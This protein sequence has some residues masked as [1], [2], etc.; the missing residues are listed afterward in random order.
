MNNPL[1]IN[2]KKW[3]S[4]KYKIPIE[5]LERIEY[6]GGDV[7]LKIKGGGELCNILDYFNN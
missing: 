6:Q 3:A 7:G 2:F 5:Q 1:M 4:K